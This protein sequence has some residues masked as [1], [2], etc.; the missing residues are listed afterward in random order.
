MRSSERTRTVGWLLSAACC[1]LL[2]CSQDSSPTG[3]T[4]I[5][6]NPPP[7]P[8]PAAK[9]SAAATPGPYGYPLPVSGHYEETNIGAFNLVDGIAYPSSGGTVVYVS[10]KPLASPMLAASICPMTQA[11]SLALLRNADFIEV[12]LGADGQSNYF[13]A[14]T[15]YKGQGRE[16]ETGSH[17]WTITPGK[18]V[19]G[20]VTGNVAYKGRGAFDFDL[21]LFKPA[22]TEVS[23]GQRASGTRI[24]TARRAPSEKELIGTYTE[25]LRAVRAKD[26]KAVLTVQGFA[27]AQIENMRGLVGIDAELAAHAER[28]LDP[29]TAEEPTVSAGYAQVGARGKNSKG[30]AFVNYY[31]FA[32]CGEKLVLVGITENPQ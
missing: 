24:D 14:G 21:P 3:G 8:A 20:H 2:Y 1:G 31:E 25:I 11:R 30:A 17:F 9:P 28:F 19:P 23:E 29:G 5:M 13:A 4:S 26:L 7:P 16:E 32:P 18:T 22:V 10:S 6:N 12:T 15:H 27:P